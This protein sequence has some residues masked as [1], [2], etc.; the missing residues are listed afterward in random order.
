M[1][2]RHEELEVITKLYLFKTNVWHTGAQLTFPGVK[3]EV[4]HAGDTGTNQPWLV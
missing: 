2:S 1:Q 4:D 3:H